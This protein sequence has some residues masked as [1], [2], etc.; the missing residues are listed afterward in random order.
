MAEPITVSNTLCNG[1]ASID[2]TA[3]PGI[4]I[5]WLD[6]RMPHRPSPAYRLNIGRS[7]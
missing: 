7:T 2:D 3:T 1:I 5:A 4:G 6:I